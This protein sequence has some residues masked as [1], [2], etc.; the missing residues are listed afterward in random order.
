MLPPKTKAIK[1][2][3]AGSSSTTASEGEAKLAVLIRLANKAPADAMLPFYPD[4]QSLLRGVF[5]MEE[6]A[7]ESEFERFLDEHFPRENF[8]ELRAFFDEGADHPIRPEDRYAYLRETREALKMIATRRRRRSIFDSDLSFPWH[9]VGEWKLDRIRLCEICGAVFFAN[10]NNQLTCGPRCSSTR[11]VRRF[12]E[13]QAQYEQA[14]K[15]RPTKGIHANR[16]SKQ[17]PKGGSN[18]TQ[19]TR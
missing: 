17:S 3:H 9:L 15:L 8:T 14:R 10:R 7:R 5:D 11:R 16:I 18:G 12:R 1:P 2:L 13:H 19:K 4:E 6:V